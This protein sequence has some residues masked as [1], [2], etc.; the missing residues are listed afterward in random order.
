LRLHS[1]KLNAVSPELL[2]EWHRALDDL[3]A[4]PEVRG[5]LITGGES[6]FFSYGLDVAGLLR[7]SRPEM[8]TFMNSF[9]RLLARLFLFPHP[10]GAAVNGHATAGGLLIALAADCRI[11]A[12]GS[13]SIGLSEVKL[14]L[15]APADALRM[16]MRRLGASITADLTLR[17]LMVSPEAACALGI[18]EK[19]VPAN[20]VLPRTLERLRD[21]VD[22]PAGAIAINKRF[23]GAGVFD[24]PAATLKQE[25][26][27]WLDR[28]FSPSAQ[29]ELRKLAEWK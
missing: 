10:V 18:F 26:S 6:P 16:M 28:W 23:L 29:A 19:V 22:M 25:T 1:G 17:G 14:G 2:D 27:E 4:D 11:G 12:E 9:H 21:L 20:E 3:E 5:L 24:L 8:E 13:F 7:L 15:A